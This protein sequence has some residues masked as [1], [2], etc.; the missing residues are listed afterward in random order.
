MQAGFGWSVKPKKEGDF[1]GREVLARQ[2]AGELTHKVVG[3]RM[4]GRQI[5]RQGYAVMQ[6]DRQ[7]GSV[8][9]GT[10]SPTLQ[11]PIATALVERAALDNGQALSIQIRSQQLPADIVPMPFYRRST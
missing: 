3:L 6:G 4:Q 1:L 8:L 7:V 9:S 11:V 5:A 10:Y 2:K